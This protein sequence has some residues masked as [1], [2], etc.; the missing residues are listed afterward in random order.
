MTNDNWNGFRALN[1]AQIRTLAENLVKEIRSRGPFLSL[2]EFVNR[3][4]EDSELGKSG[5]I[6]A[7]IEAGKL[8]EPASQVPFSIDKY[9]PKSQ[10][11][12]STT[13]ASAFPDS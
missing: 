9:P 7:A 3:R 12:S 10:A 11:T 5:A 1:D 13:P 8:N 6:Q 4:V 2:A